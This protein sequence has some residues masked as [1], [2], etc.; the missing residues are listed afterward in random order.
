MRKKSVQSVHFHHLLDD[1]P[2][3]LYVYVQEVQ[4]ELELEWLMCPVGHG[5][6]TTSFLTLSLE[7]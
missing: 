4:A 6:T 2:S 1:L 7:V 5:E 3:Y